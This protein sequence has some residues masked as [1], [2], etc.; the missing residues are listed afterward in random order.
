MLKPTSILCL[1]ALLLTACG[2]GST[3]GIEGY[4][5]GDINIAVEGSFVPLIEQEVMVFNQQYPDAKIT[6]ITMSE[7]AA[8]EQLLNDS[9]QLAVIPRQLTP[10]ELAYIEKR[11]FRAKQILVAYDAIALILHKDNPN[12]QM[13]HED[14]IGILSGQKKLW[15]QVGEGNRIGNDSINIVIDEPGSSI[16]RYVADSVLQGSNLPGNIYAAGSQQAVLDYVAENPN[17]MGL[18]GLAYVSD[19]NAD[20]VLGFL[21][22]VQVASL[23][24]ENGN[25]FRGPYQHY[26]RDKTYPLLRPVYFVHFEPKMGVATTFTNF[27]NGSDGQL[28]IYKMDLLPSQLMVRVYEIQN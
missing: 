22:K 8:V 2:G 13:V 19:Q 17:A 26:I 25:E 5:R 6:T 18:V 16:V 4:D 9:V 12:R 28:I 21:E 11:Q 10:E 3:S 27:V 1:I 15:S 24:Y 20:D 7:E 14:Y 23:Y